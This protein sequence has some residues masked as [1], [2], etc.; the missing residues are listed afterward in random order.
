MG[1]NS[2]Y[3][4]SSN[5]M[6]KCQCFDNDPHI[7]H[8]QFKRYHIQNW[9]WTISHNTALIQS[10]SNKIPTDIITL[11][12]DHSFH[13]SEEYKVIHPILCY[14]KYY[15]KSNQLLCKPL[16]KRWITQQQKQSLAAISLFVAVHSNNLMYGHKLLDKLRA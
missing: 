1:V 15:P 10:L 9:I 4:H 14:Q 11:I 16:C 3:H 5:C 6:S 13:H 7:K 12:K 8:C 2:S